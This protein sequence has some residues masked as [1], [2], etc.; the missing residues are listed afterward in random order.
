[1]SHIQFVNQMMIWEKRLEIEERKRRYDHLKASNGHETILVNDKEKP[2]EPI[3]ES[4]Y[5]TRWRHP[6]YSCHSQDSCE[7]T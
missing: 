4:L 6:F 3:Q 7:K 2:R 5:V 1:M